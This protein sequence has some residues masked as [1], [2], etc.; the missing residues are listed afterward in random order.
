MP[1]K[2]QL[3]SYSQ[4]SSAPTSKVAAAGIGGSLTVVLVYILGQFNI[5]PPAE[6]VA[7]LT[8]LVSFGSGYIVRE[9]RVVQ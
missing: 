5:D 6:V 4:V 8:T 2:I 7:A 9:K 3:E 1:K